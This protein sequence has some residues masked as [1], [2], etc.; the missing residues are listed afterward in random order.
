MVQINQIISEYVQIEEQQEGITPSGR[1]DISNI[2]FD[3]LRRE[4]AKTRKKNLIIKDLDQLVQERIA[5]LLFSNPQRINYYERYQAI[6]EEYNGEQD[7]AAIEKTFMDLMTLAKSLDEEEQRYVREEFANDEELS[8][9]DLLYK[10]GLTKQEIKKLKEVSASLLQKIKQKISELDHWTD[11]EETKSTI[12]NLIRKT[13]W[14]ELPESYSD[15]S[16]D[17]YRQRIFEYV[18]VRYQDIA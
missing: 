9:Y 17:E 4:F 5:A 12:E 6:I 11:K 13:L 18:M 7:R 2:D 1:F 15:E 8:I 16:I 3:L 10:E 14:K